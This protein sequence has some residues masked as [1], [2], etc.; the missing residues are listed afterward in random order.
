MT[1]VQM[2]PFPALQILSAKELF[3]FV[4]AS[5]ECNVIFSVLYDVFCCVD[6]MKVMCMSWF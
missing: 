6:E 5:D 3:S 4:G 2:H 1:V